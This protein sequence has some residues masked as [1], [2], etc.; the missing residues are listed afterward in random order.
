MT[1]RYRSVPGPN[2]CSDLR[3]VWRATIKTQKA[4]QF[5]KH[6]KTTR[7]IPKKTRTQGRKDVALWF[8]KQTIES[9]GLV[10]QLQQRRA[11]KKKA[12][13]ENK[14]TNKKEK[15]GFNVLHT[16]KNYR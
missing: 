10:Q 2:S 16:N 11:K 8:L 14:E 6:S 5:P 3:H 4:T 1:Y 15:L 7:P 12:K 9:E 13:R